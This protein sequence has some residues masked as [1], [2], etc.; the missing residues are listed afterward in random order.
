MRGDICHS[1]I[2]W[3]IST[4]NELFG[5]QVMNTQK[6][7]DM[8]WAKVV[9]LETSTENYYLKIVARSFSIEPEVLKA[10]GWFQVPEMVAEN[11]DLKCFILR[12]AGQPL[13]G[14]GFNAEHAKEVLTLCAQIQI[15]CIDR[16]D[17]FL[18][19]GVNDW[20]L[21]RLP[22]LARSLFNDNQLL[23]KEGLS[24][25]AINALPS[26]L[27]KVEQLCASLR[28]YG[29]PQTLEHGDFQ[30]KN[31]LIRE[32]KFSLCDWGD[33]SITHPFFSCVSF[34]NSAVRHHGLSQDAE[35]Y[36]FLKE[37]Y[38]SCWVDYG[39]RQELNEAYQLARKLRPLVFALNFA[40]VYTCYNVPIPQEF[41]GHIAGAI[42]K[43]IQ[44]A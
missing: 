40:K 27:S 19:R 37:A 24:A 41:T 42:L 44:E 34:L 20:R 16:V 32:G 7:W 23:E 38:L 15:N 13:R 14:Y 29:V 2:D 12:D 26:L 11:P 21:N 30:D 10:L 28:I 43:L 35:P 22:G 6:I 25:D 8:P 18:S 31:I 3:A 4:L 36:I 1:A 9:R 5:A 17:E 39:R 33:V